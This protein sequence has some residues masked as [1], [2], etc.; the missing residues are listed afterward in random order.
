VLNHALERKRWSSFT[1]SYLASEPLTLQAG[2]FFVDSLPSCDAYLVMEI[3]H[4]WGDEESVAILKAIRQAAPSHAK[5]LLIETIIPDDP[6]PH[7][8]KML[9]IQM[10]M[11][12]GGRQRTQQEY[13]VLFDRAGFSLQRAI[14]TGADTTILEA[15]PA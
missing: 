13:E 12:L 5:L 14:D 3:I 1:D 7:W 10:L 15:I 2:D 6:G 11:M 8:A 9:D 4:N